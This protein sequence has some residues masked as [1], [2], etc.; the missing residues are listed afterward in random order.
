M[1]SFSNLRFLFVSLAAIVILSAIENQG[2]PLASAVRLFGCCGGAHSLRHAPKNNSVPRYRTHPPPSNQ[3]HHHQYHQEQQQQQRQRRRDGFSTHKTHVGETRGLPK[4]S[5]ANAIR[6]SRSG[7]PRL[8]SPI[9][10][11]SV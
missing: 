7:R 3:S 1:A 11:T 2:P 9:R 10:E 4:R 5:V 6:V 8:P